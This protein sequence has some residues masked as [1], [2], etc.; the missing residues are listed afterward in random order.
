[1]LGANCGL[2]TSTAREETLIFNEEF[3]DFNLDLWKHEITMV[4]RV[5]VN[6]L[7]GEERGRGRIRRMLEAIF[8]R[9]ITILLS[10][11]CNTVL[12]M[13]VM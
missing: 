2:L 13:L 9:C 6:V 8:A 12:V 7:E 3:Q 11:R 4:R 1:M 10:L 5:C